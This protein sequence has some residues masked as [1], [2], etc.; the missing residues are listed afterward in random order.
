MIWNQRSILS[1]AAVS[2][3]AMAACSGDS[4]NGTPDSGSPVDTGAD[5]AATDGAPAADATVVT[6]GG[7]DSQS[8]TETGT[9][10]ASVDAGTDGTGPSD[11]SADATCDALPTV[12]DL[13]RGVWLICNALDVNG[14]IW[15]GILTISSETPTCDG[16]TLAGSFSWVTTN[17]GMFQG[18]TVAQGSYAAASHLITLT[19]SQ[20]TGSVVSGTDVMTY[21][22]GTDR[23]VNGSWTPD[24]GMWSAAS[25]VAQDAGASCTDGG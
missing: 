24:D 3:L 6:D 17:K 8:V 13:T 5:A 4:S 16:A 12:P 15:T 21:D 1:L 7:T 22:P 14:K 19:E 10:D 18:T 2:A 20:P 11:A 9:S 23:L 25:R